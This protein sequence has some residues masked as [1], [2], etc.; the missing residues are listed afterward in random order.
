MVTGT[1][2]THRVFLGQ[3]KAWNSFPRI[4]DNRACAAHRICIAA[5][6]G[7][8][9]GK[10]LQEVEGGS[11]PAENGSRGALKPAN[12]LVWFHF[13]PV[14]FLPADCDAAW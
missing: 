3:T 2:A 1:A 7:G 9:C 5:C 12:F 4:Q 14:T 6:P 8:R 11:F 10:G 13:I